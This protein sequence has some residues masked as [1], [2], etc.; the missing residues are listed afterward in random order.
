[1]L[2]RSTISISRR[3]NLDS[4]H[5][6]AR[7]FYFTLSAPVVEKNAKELVPPST[8]SRDVCSQTKPGE[9]SPV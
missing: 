6:R 1:M 9:N 7:T 4:F 2:S 5:C 8:P 3:L